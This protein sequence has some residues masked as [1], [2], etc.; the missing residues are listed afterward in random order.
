MQS[1]SAYTPRNCGSVYPECNTVPVYETVNSDGV[2]VILRGEDHNPLKGLDPSS[3][4]LS[5][6]LRA[7]VNPTAITRPTIGFDGADGV[8]RIEHQ[9][10]SNPGFAKFAK[11]NN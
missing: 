3:F 10:S 6:D 8:D 11:N 2:P 1:N 9:V 7:G 4:S 5:S